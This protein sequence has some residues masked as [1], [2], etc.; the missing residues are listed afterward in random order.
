MKM[1]GGG[2]VPELVVYMDDEPVSEVG[3]DGGNGPLAVDP[4]NRTGEQP[5]WIG[6]YPSDVEII[7]DRFRRGLDSPAEE[8]QPESR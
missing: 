2:L 1:E 5:I 3:P 4:H 7:R 6:G 8:G